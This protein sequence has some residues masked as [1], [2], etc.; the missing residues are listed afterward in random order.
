MF[1]EYAYPN[2]KTLEVTIVGDILP[3]EANDHLAI[4]FNYVVDK[5]YKY[6]HLNLKDATWNESLEDSFQII[7]NFESYGLPEG[8]K[9][10]IT[11]TTDVIQM[12]FLQTFIAI[13]KM[14]N[15]SFFKEPDDARAWLAFS[16]NDM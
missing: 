16:V 9:I 7:S 13:R 4:F 12:H 14:P 5:G 1:F 2:D 8:Y 3:G 11:F 6:V 15:I 10:A